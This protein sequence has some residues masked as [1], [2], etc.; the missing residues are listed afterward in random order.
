MKEIAIHQILQHT[1]PIEWVCWQQKLYVPPA[2]PNVAPMHQV[3][4]LVP[5]S[6]QEC[7]PYQC[8]RSAETVSNFQSYAIYINI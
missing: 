6:S 5:S 7:L 2:L 3:K 1:S 4:N 8:P